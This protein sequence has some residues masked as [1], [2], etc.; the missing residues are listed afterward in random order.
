M[1]EET[2]KK[3]FWQKQRT[4]LLQQST[5][6][7]QCLFLSFTLGHKDFIYNHSSPISDHA[8]IPTKGVTEVFFKF[9][10]ILVV[11]FF[12]TYISFLSFSRFTGLD[13]W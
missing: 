13:A 11:S 5:L 1:F 7:Q 6:H 12:H 8:T 10:P 4:H 3:K 2:T 9:F